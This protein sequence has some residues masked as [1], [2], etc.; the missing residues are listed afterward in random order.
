MFLPV[1]ALAEPAWLSGEG[2]R[3]VHVLPEPLGSAEPRDCQGT[4]PSVSMEIGTSV[5]GWVLL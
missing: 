2:G 5:M 4:N 1:C 3:A